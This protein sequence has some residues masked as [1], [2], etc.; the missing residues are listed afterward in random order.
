VSDAPYRAK[1]VEDALV[2]T[3]GSA[4]VLAAA[5]SKVVGGRPVNSDIHAGRD[6]RA[7]MAAVIARRALES[8]LARIG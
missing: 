8:A 3:D 5:V 7:A 2:G 1:E 4:D 6:Y